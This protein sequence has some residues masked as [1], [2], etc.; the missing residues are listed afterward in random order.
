MEHRSERLCQ[1]RD[2]YRKEPHEG[3][4]RLPFVK[5]AKTRHNAENRRYDRVSRARGHART[6]LQ[7]G[8]TASLAV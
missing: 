1:I 2:A 4:E 3:R 7:Q 8:A 6:G 5:M